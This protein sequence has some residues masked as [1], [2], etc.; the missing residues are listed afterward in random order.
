MGEL[1]T[2]KRKSDSSEVAR[3]DVTLA[4]AAGRSLVVTLWGAKA[5][6]EIPVASV[7]QITSCRVGDFNGLSLSALS[8]SHVIVE[9]VGA[10]P[11]ALR[12]WFAAE[13]ASA[14]FTPVGEALRPKCVPS[15]SL[16]SLPL[17]AVSLLFGALRPP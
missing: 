10:G 17:P 12:R 16:L 8:R 7:I 4:D 1:G 5:A 3:R 2:I 13:G 9:P 6:E 14:E 15:P 11:D